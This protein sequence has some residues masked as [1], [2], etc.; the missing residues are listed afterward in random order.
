MSNANKKKAKGKSKPSASAEEPPSPSPPYRRRRRDRSPTSQRSDS[1][2]S[3]E[4][5]SSHG[6]EPETSNDISKSGSSSRE[7]PSKAIPKRRRHRGDTPEASDHEGP[8]E[9]KSSDA[10]LQLPSREEDVEVSYSPDLDEEAEWTDS[11]PWGKESEPWDEPKND[12]H[13]RKYTL[14]SQRCSTR[15][16]EYEKNHLI[17]GMDLHYGLSLI[18]ISE[19]T[20]PY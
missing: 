11:D 9:D 2:D 1:D 16:R 6:D 5:Y 7:V 14:L 12:K 20:R 4:D 15:Y 19:P 8:V 10:P 13:G 17:S 18:H 3:K